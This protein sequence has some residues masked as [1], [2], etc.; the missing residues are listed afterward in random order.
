MKTL[1]E[2]PAG[3]KKKRMML[4]SPWP[5]R[6]PL[7]CNATT[8]TPNQLNRWD[9]LIKVSSLSVSSIPA[10]FLH[11]SIYLLKPY[12]AI[13]MH[14]KFAVFPEKSDKEEKGFQER[15][16]NTGPG[17]FSL[18]SALFQRKVVFG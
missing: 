10:A 4:T 16:P 1:L 18:P 2:W 14:S 12:R 13:R 11:I 5:W 7:M 17:F 3:S 8:I 6:T 15:M 9:S